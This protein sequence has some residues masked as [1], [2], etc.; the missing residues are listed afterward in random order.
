MGILSNLFNKFKSNGVLTKPEAYK[1]RKIYNP[2]TDEDDVQIAKAEYEF[3]NTSRGA[4]FGEDYLTQT[5]V[6]NLYKKDTWVY[7]I[8][9]AKAISVSALNIQLKKNTLKDNKIESEIIT[10]HPIL[11][12]L[13]N[14]NP[15][16]TKSLFLQGIVWSLELDGNAY[17]ELVKNG[18]DIKEMYLLRPDQVELIP[19][20]QK[21]VKGYRYNVNGKSN[22]LKREDVLHIRYY[23]P[24]GAL[25][26]LAPFEAAKNMVETDSS[27]IE[28]MRFLIRNRAVPDGMLVF[29]VGTKR[30][31]IERLKRMWESRHQGSKNAGKVGVMWNGL[32]FK[33]TSINPKD[34]E[35]INL[36]KMARD[37]LFAVGNTM[38]V[39]HGVMDQTCLKAGELVKTPTGLKAIESLKINDEVFSID[40]ATKKQRIN[41]IVQ[42][43]KPY[44]TK[45]YKI[46]T[47]SCELKVSDNHPFLALIPY[48][49]KGVS[50]YQTGK[51]NYRT[52]F[53]YKHLRD[54]KIGDIVAT[55]N[56]HEGKQNRAKEYCELYGVFLG[57][58]GRS[59]RS[60]HFYLTNH[61]RELR[62][63]YIAQA[64]KIGWNPSDIHPTYFTAGC[65]TAVLEADEWVG[66][67]YTKRMASWVWK[68]SIENR[69]AVLRGLLDSDGHISKHHKFVIGLVNKVL[70]QDIQSLAKSCGIRTSSI[71]IRPSCTKIFPNGKEYTSKQSFRSQICDYQGLLRIGTHDP[72]Y[73]P[74]LLKVP[75]K[76]KGRVDGVML[77]GNKTIYN[78]E[79]IRLERVKS[80]EY[81]STELVYDIEVERDH[82][83]IAGGFVVHNSFANAN[84]QLK[85]YTME[86]IVPLANTIIDFF[87]KFLIQPTYGKEFQLGVDY[88]K[89]LSTLDEE[90]QKQRIIRENFKAGIITLDEMRID[91]GL[92]I[93]TDEQRTVFQLVDLTVQVQALRSLRRELLRWRDLIAALYV[94][95]ESDPD[96]HAAAFRCLLRFTP[97]A[98]KQL[99][100]LSPPARGRDAGPG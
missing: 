67:T 68:E 43:H 87:N 61:K 22:I 72:M 45:I 14:P 28:H 27:A 56:G 49:A 9:N 2:E 99:S 78:H 13:N 80:I 59:T 6:Y 41:K 100:A 82:N 24:S 23:N 39:K 60:Y 10:N 62:E 70:V 31:D 1:Y 34:M 26:G 86:A 85:L 55:D 3:F 81:D 57:D 83:F 91:L 66:N 36:R 52:Q 40:T 51:L 96:A 4:E 92:P 44:V 94:A 98:S 74:R 65:P 38:P 88:G 69:L 89:S 93:A 8:I 64:K 11:D 15:Q 7:V 71:T 25:D 97:E 16:D 58:G 53:V 46:K 37:E 75:L 90:E 12:V 20:V 30:E 95:P 32:D 42:C 73:I 17:I 33:Q 79:G 76:R 47:A 29:P 77:S 84:I 48:L 54:L 5:D 18:K 63:K 50:K 21:G 19:D 35:Y